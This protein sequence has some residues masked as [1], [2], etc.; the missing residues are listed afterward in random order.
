MATRIALA[1]LCTVTSFTPPTPHRAEVKLRKTRGAGG[2]LVDPDAGAPD[3]DVMT[4]LRERMMQEELKQRK[5]TIKEGNGNRLSAQYVELL[6]AQ[7]PSELVGAF[8]READPRVQVAIQDAIMGMLG[9]GA[10]DIEFTTTGSRIAEL[11]FRLQMTGYMLRNAEYVLALQ[12]VLKLAPTGR[13][14][15]QLRA[16]FSRVDTDNSGYIDADEVQNLFDDVYG[17]L[18]DTASTAEINDL[19]Q[20]KKADVES[21]VRF[22]DANS[23]G[24][25]SFA[26]FCRALGGADASPAQQALDKFSDSKLLEAPSTPTPI[27]GELKVGDR[28]VEAS[29][30]VAELKAE[31]ARLKNELATYAQSSG[32]NSLAAIGQYIASIDPEQRDLLV[33]KMTPEAREAAAELV[34]YVL[35]DSSPEGAGQKLEPDQ[36]VTMERRILDQIC[37]WQIVVGYR[38]RELEASGEARRRLG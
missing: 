7:H 31:A 11:C 8:Y 3:D 10:V 1:L 21:F 6:T 22:F 4:E 2:D 28:T 37:R 9:A 16:A 19:K 18:P 38:L 26:E 20:R 13:T 33:S 15:A 27:T 32:Q 23:D 34:N 25:I 30:Y 29:D 12:D 14:P 36:Q 17:D 24:K 5:Q 35:K